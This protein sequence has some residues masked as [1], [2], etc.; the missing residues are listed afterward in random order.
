MS[1]KVKRLSKYH[2]N[3]IKMKHHIDQLVGYTYRYRIDLD[4]EI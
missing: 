4:C 1:S 2:S 3:D